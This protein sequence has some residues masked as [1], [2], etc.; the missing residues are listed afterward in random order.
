M[1]RW[2]PKPQG[3]RPAP[4]GPLR[5]A[6]T[7]PPLPENPYRRFFTRTP[8]FETLVRRARSA[9]KAQPGQPEKP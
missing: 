3:G 8:T 9:Q 5:A 7:V 1:M 4:S 2:R 6:R